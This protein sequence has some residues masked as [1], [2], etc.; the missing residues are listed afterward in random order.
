[1]E[2][3]AALINADALIQLW[4]VE[5]KLLSLGFPIKVIPLEDEIRIA[6]RGNPA[7]EAAWDSAWEDPD[8]AS[9]GFYELMHKA[10]S[11]E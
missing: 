9:A 1:L 3:A 11:D 6:S 8:L 5:Y 10:F 4:R 7:I 2:K